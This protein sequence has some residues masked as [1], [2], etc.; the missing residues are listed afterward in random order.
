MGKNSS[1]QEIWK[2]LLSA[3]RIAMSLHFD[4]DGDSL[5]CCVSMKYVLESEGKYIKIVSKDNIDFGLKELNYSK[6]VEFGKSI[7]DLDL[8][9]FDVVLILDSG[10]KKQFVDEKFVFPQ[11][12]FLINIDHHASN[13]FFGDLNYVDSSKTSC[14]SVLLDFFREIK[15]EIDKELA[16]LLLLGIYTD[17]GYFSHDNG[18]SI[19]DAAFLIDKGADYLDGIVN[20]IKYNASLKVKKYYGLLYNNFKIVK[21]GKFNVGYTFATLNDI[22]KLGLNKSDVNGGTNDTQ[23]IGGVDIL[24]ALTETEN[25][26][27]GSLRTRKKIDVSLLAKELGG[28]GH[29]AAAG[30]RLEK[31]PMEKAEEKVLGVIEA[32]IKLKKI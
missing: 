13:D 14:C 27:K 25:V 20:K 2:K 19:K 30:F 18:S 32:A 31:M 22:K 12:I 6:E 16:S 3:K 9:K 7:S 29:K 8:E 21:I 28:G 1:F 10:S 17:S 24:F 15:I 23:E 5:A 4:P 26:I 11:N